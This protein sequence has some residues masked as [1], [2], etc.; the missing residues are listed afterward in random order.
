MAGGGSVSRPEFVTNRPGDAPDFPTIPHG[1]VADGV[2]A[3]LGAVS[4]HGVD[5]WSVDVATAYFN[6]G[7]WE[8][9]ADTFQGGADGGRPGRVRL[10][11]GAEPD[12]ELPAP[13]QLSR[14]VQPEEYETKRIQ[15]AVSEH[16]QAIRWDRSMVEFDEASTERVRRMVTWLRHDEVEVRRLTD[17]FLHGKAVLTRVA[18]R[19]GYWEPE[20]ALVGSANFTE[21]GLTTNLELGV[22]RYDPTPVGH[23][24]AWFDWLWERAEFYD[25]AGLYD[26]RVRFHRPR[27][28]WLRMLW[29]KYGK[30][31]IAE[32][33][34]TGTG[35]RLTKFQEHGAALARDLIE[36]NQGAIIA[37]GVGLGK[38]YT[39]GR[40]IHDTVRNRQRALAVVPKALRGTWE[41]FRSDHQLAFDVHTYEQI[42]DEP[43]LGGEGK[44]ALRQ[45]PDDYALVV[46]DEAHAFRNP[47]NQRSAALKRLVS[48]DPPKRVAL[49]TATPVNNS[50]M[51]LYHLIRI[52]AP[53]DAQFAHLGIPS[54]ARRFK[55]AASKS[56]D[57]LDTS[58]L[59]DIVDAV[60]VKRTRRFV[61]EN[62]EGE[63]VWA[64][65][66]Y[67]PIRFPQPKVTRVDYDLSRVMPGFF[68]RFARALGYDPEELDTE[69]PDD[70]LT[71]ARYTPSRYRSDG[72]VDD[73]ERQ[74]A[75]LLRSGLLKRME[76]SARAFATTCERMASA[77]DD[78][79]AALDDGW[80]ATSAGIEDWKEAQARDGALD[81]PDDTD[82]QPASLYDAH[83]LQ[84]DV[85]ADRDL[86]QSFAREARAVEPERDPKLARLADELVE[87]VREA[88]RDAGHTS[89]ATLRKTIVF[90]YFADTA[91]WIY[92]HL[93]RLVDPHDSQYDA[94][95]APFTGHLAI[96]HGGR[97][98]TETAARGFAPDHAGGQADEHDLLVATDVL[99]EGVNLQQ[100]R[101]VVNYDLPW[102]PMRLVQRHGRIDRI[103]SPHSVVYIRCFFPDRDLN[104]VLDLVG[105]LDRKIA[106]AAASVGVE[107]EV[108]PGT[109]TT[110]MVFGDVTD[111]VRRLA[112]GDASIL[113]HGG[114]E[115]EVASSE[116]FRQE[117]RNA[118]A[119]A[120]EKGRTD[121]DA[122]G[123]FLEYLPWGIGSGVVRGPRRAF[124]FCARVGDHEEPVFRTVIYSTTG[125]TEVS[126]NL[127]G[128][129]LTARTA[130]GEEPHMDDALFWEAFDAWK[131][132]R[133][134]ITERWQE[135][136]DP[137]AVQPKIPKPFH[138]ARALLMRVEP[139][140]V[141]AERIDAA[142]DALGTPYPDS[143]SRIVGYALDEAGSEEDRAAAVVE[144]VELLGIRAAPPPQTLPEIRQDDVHLVAWLAVV[145]M[146]NEDAG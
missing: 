55:E 18:R 30:G 129:L 126:E 80:V 53:S 54:L 22:G 40:L 75:G 97:G 12:Q 50:V 141:A 102:N 29:E 93:A 25:L 36:R 115:A 5:R 84:A 78:F 82:L 76:S 88:Q 128:A 13:R 2:R 33:E 38:T 101:N 17:R 57:E 28:I 86:L 104:R 139:P 140:E 69:Q 132:A 90:S 131:V 113:E 83:E 120:V 31:V 48:G 142:Y 79:L 62:Y 143:Y 37:D 123:E 125:D 99:A 105:R 108:L 47:G 103:G 58:D 51:D 8:Q 4:V 7:G 34:K 130:P 52:F 87:V 119:E 138:D 133:A 68:E 106:H 77:H 112:E 44:A 135:A 136:T 15:D 24:A 66:E 117:L 100:A 74:I 94:R 32:G 134:D 21:A 116:E 43:R 56:V 70:G 72:A 65:G 1:T 95:L 16:E 73:K 85:H 23:V 89:A 110:E 122:P 91:D 71:L 92:E 114:T 144:A 63:I 9:L 145:P 61:K 26:E 42:R 19:A 45:D 127:L 124:V 39:A 49:L 121:P 67:Q 35:L 96:V 146:S 41:Q 111:D 64:N 27:L 46:I 14:E 11:L 107:R 98:D 109:R 10:L 20:G 3:M 118:L 137:R 60:M 59:F 6:P 81:P